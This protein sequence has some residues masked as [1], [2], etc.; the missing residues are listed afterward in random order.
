MDV[1]RRTLRVGTRT[2][3]MARQQSAQVIE[4]LR[5]HHAQVEVTEVPMLASGDRHAGDLAAIGGKSAW[6]R[7]LD[8][9]LL[10]RDLDIAVSCAKDCPSPH[11]RPAG[12]ATGAVL[13][14]DD[15]RDALILPAGRR[16]VGFDDLPAG[17]R[18]A[19]SA[20]R[21]AAQIRHRRPDLEVVALRGNLNTRLD[22]IDAG[23][24]DAAVVAYSGLHRI[25][26]ADRAVEV[27]D[28]ERWCPAAGAG[29]I[30][31][32]HRD[33]DDVVRDLLAPLTHPPTEQ[34]L[35]GERAVLTV[36]QGHCRSPL[37]AH[38]TRADD[39]TLRLQAAVW[40]LDGQTMYEATGHGDPGHSEKIGAQ[41][42]SAL[43]QQ[44]ACDLID[45]D[46][47]ASTPRPGH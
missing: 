16:A 15:P 45:N 42:A 47:Q 10:S 40:S 14:R 18:I 46:R 2:S 9:G 31:I 11:D 33:D 32:E 38:A 30:V 28:I 3:A 43:V 36:L 44:G 1:A 21:R 7:E 4:L 22:R 41:V 25:G 13:E 5:Q 39:R 29:V 23:H 24:A 6:V 26:R 37:A 20:P 17:A 27:F 35:A 8:A 19:T 34:E 12:I